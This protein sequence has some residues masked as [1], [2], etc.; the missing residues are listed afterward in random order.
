MTQQVNTPVCG[1]IRFWAH[2]LLPSTTAVNPHL[3]QQ[4]A[5]FVQLPSLCQGLRRWSTFVARAAL[6]PRS[7]VSLTLGIGLLLLAFAATPAL[8]KL[9]F[10]EHLSG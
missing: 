8:V 6:H 1:V 9:P 3:L 10:W 4:A 2:F 7:F 5:E